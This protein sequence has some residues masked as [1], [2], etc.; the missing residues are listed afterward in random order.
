MARTAS[1]RVAKAFSTRLKLNLAEIQPQNHQNVKK[2][3]FGKV[4]GV[5]GLRGEK[6]NYKSVAKEMKFGMSHDH[7]RKRLKTRTEWIVF[8]I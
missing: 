8:E 5:N 2:R 4:P 7:N 3:N 6:L 1:C